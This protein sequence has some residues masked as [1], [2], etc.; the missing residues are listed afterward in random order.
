M[1]VV[2]KHNNWLLYSDNKNY[3]LDVRCNYGIVEPT[4]TF[5][6][7]EEEI[8]NY[9]NNGE[10]ILHELSNASCTSSGKHYYEKMRPVSEPLMQEV[11]KAT[12]NYINQSY[13]IV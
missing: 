13:K 2:A 7:K 4:A 1:K 3:I 11:R 8:E 6:L 9:L 12:K 5:M 10:E